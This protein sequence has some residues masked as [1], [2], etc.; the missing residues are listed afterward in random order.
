VFGLNLFA[1]AQV[2]D[3]AGHLQDA[4]MRA[5]KSQLLLE[6]ELGMASN[7]VANAGS[8]DLRLKAEISSGRVFACASPDF[9][10]KSS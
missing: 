7:G 9:N 8:G 2:G 10:R 5:D 3:G 6:H 1:P 4:I